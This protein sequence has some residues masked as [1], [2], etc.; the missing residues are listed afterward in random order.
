MTKN[1]MPAVL[2]FRNH[3]ALFA[4]EKYFWTRMAISKLLFAALFMVSPASNA[5][6]RLALCRIP[7]QLFVLSLLPEALGGPD[8]A[9]TTIVGAV[10]VYRAFVL[11][12][13][14]LFADNAPYW[15]PYQGYPWVW[16]WGK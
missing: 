1:A 3:F 2:L 16:L 13:W 12:V 9:N 11:G 6:D 15:L 7:L 4:Q 10:V 8:A 14:L 5:I